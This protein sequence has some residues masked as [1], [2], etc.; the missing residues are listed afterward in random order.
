MTQKQA[1]AWFVYKDENQ[2]NEFLSVFTDA[3]KLP[4]TFAGW[5]RQAEH[6]IQH[7]E[8]NGVVV[9]RVHAETTGEFIAWC[10]ANDRGIDASGRKGFAFFKAAEHL[11]N[12]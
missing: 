10:L 12:R 8:K 2:Y 6:G 7:L 9:I 3:R 5:E 4:S 11:G 1:V